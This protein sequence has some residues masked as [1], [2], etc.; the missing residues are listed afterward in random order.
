MCIFPIISGDE[1][2]HFQNILTHFVNFIALAVLSLIIGIVL[3]IY[4]Y[5]LKPKTIVYGQKKA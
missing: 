2:V 3:F 1:D 5:Y 4:Q